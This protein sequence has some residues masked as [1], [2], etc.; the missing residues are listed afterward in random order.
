[1]GMTSRRMLPQYDCEPRLG[2]L[3]SGSAVASLGMMPNIRSGRA[4]RVRAALAGVVHRR[5]GSARAKHDHRE[6]NQQGGVHSNLAA[7]DPRHSQL[8]V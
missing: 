4:P 1:M 8:Q 3:L 7:A 6:Y 2:S 5:Q